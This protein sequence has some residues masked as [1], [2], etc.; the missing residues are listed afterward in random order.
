MSTHGKLTGKHQYCEF[1]GETIANRVKQM[2]DYR[3]SL[4]ITDL[5]IKLS[6]GN[7]KTGS[8]VPSISTIPIADCG[9]NCSCCAKGCYAV[10][11]VACYDASRKMMAQNSAIARGDL[12]R[13]FREIDAAVKFIRFFRY[14]VAG[15]ITCPA[16][17]TGM[18]DVA[19]KNP[20]C[21][22]L[23]FTKQ[24]RIVNDY[25]GD[26][27]EGLPE[28]LHIIFSEW[29][30]LTVPN[31]YNLPTSRP[32]WNGETAEGIMCNGNCSECAAFNCGCWSLKKGERVLFEAH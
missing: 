16:Y 24:F 5:H 8:L 26:H 9:A 6:Y 29:R 30:G 15:D 21:Q 25:L 19:I 1:K 31:P 27:A 4:D 32:L 14:H 28:N 23:C 18:V 17:L 2:V 11:N 12:P 13:Y 10:R 3:D 7:R 22:F 20:H